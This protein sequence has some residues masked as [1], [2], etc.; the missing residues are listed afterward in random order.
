ME[1]IF[2]S[3]TLV[4]TR[5]T[6]R[7]IKEDGIPPVTSGLSGPDILL[8]TVF[9]NTITL[10][11]SLHVRDHVSRP[12]GTEIITAL[13]NLIFMFSTADEK[14]KY[15]RLVASVTRIQSPLNFL[16]I[17]VVPKYMNCVTHFQMICLVFYVQILTSIQVP[18]QQQVLSLLCIYF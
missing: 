2:F 17:T 8:S 9:S 7:H 6:R 4:L 12:Y 16:V 11:S 1:A 10:C 13:N 14:I 5:A 18:K 3:E 15:S